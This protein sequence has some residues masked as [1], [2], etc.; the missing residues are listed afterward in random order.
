MKT[1]D[2]IKNDNRFKDV[3]CCLSCHYEW[4]DGYNEPCEEI[5]EGETYF[6][7]CTIACHMGELKREEL[8]K[9]RG[10]DRGL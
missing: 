4:E 1:C 6:V 5:F 10:S 9:C 3:E 7:C 2:D 8:R